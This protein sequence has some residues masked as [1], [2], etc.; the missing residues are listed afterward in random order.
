MNK[1]KIIRIL[2]III[3]I[4]MVIIIT[5]IINKKNGKEDT[6]KKEN[7]KFK[8]QSIMYD[9]NASLEDLKKEYKVTG[10]DD[11]YEI[12][13]EYDGRKVL[14]VK[15]DINYK[16]AFTGMIKGMQPK[17]D[18]IEN[19][20]NDNYL[21]K[22]GIWVEKNS[23]KQILNFLN[24][25]LQSQ[26]NIDSDGYLYVEEKKEQ[27]ENDQKIEKLLNSH[28]KILLSISDEYYMV[29]NVTGNIV[30]NPWKDFDEYQIYDY[31]ANKDDIIL[32]LTNNIDSKYSTQEIYDSIFKL[33]NI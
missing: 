19:I 23:Q 28:K 2:S 31:V 17:F 18:E 20:Y 13:T 4:V 26:Y 27:N 25:S 15:E 22:D 1:K 7:A 32:F 16:V 21:K 30:L 6:F 3:A 10:D 8:E 5:I 9:Q 24:K 11:L 14:Q 29:D 12:Q 33:F